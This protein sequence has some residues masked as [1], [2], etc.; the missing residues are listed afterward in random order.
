[1]CRFGAV[2]SNPPAIVH[3]SSRLFYNSCVLWWHVFWLVCEEQ[4]L[5]EQGEIGDRSGWGSTL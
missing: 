5:L 1:M 4:P 3:V 2:R